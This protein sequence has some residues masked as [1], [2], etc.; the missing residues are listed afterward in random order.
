MQRHHDNGD[1]R[2]RRAP[3]QHSGAQGYG[4]RTDDSHEPRWAPTRT[5]GPSEQPADM[6]A[7]EHLRDEVCSRLEQARELDTSDL[8]VSVTNGEVT[9][10][11][12]VPVRPMKYAIEDLCDHVDGVV[13]IHNQL[14]V[15][16]ES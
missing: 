7:D 6:R 15:R 8:E 4:P 10:T 2:D 3:E 16:R 5:Q 1:D 14:R 12:S 13:E 9:L 11:G